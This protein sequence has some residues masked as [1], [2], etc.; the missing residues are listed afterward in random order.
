MAQNLAGRS[1]SDL[2]PPAGQAVSSLISSLL[3]WQYL[4]FTCVSIGES[5]V[6]GVA[7]GVSK[8]VLK[9]TNKTTTEEQRHLM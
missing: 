8:Q 4:E 6:C 2:P 9:Q 1:I 5:T 7:D 3:C